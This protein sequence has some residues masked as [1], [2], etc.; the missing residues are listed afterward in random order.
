MIQRY[1]RGML[2]GVSSHGSTTSRRPVGQS[3][4]SPRHQGLARMEA[5]LQQQQEQAKEEQYAA[6]TTAGT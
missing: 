4:R 5:E 2:T 6:F 3:E 1:Y